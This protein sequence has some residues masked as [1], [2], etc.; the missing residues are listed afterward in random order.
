MILPYAT[1]KNI[2]LKTN[3]ENTL[4]NSKE[5]GMETNKRK[6]YNVCVCVFICR[7]GSGNDNNRSVSPN[8]LWLCVCVIWR[9]RIWSPNTVVTFKVL[10]QVAALCVKMR[11][12]RLKV[13]LFYCAAFG[14]S[15]SLQICTALKSIVNRISFKDIFILTNYGNKISSS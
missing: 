6:K 15:E 7:L 8:G 11:L 1:S 5:V 3:I 10:T 13:Q 4:I 9:S 14:P 12:W 2:P